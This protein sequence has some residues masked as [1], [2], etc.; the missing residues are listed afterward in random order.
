MIINSCCDTY[1]WSLTVNAIKNRLE[2]RVGKTRL[3][4]RSLIVKVPGAQ[5]LRTEVESVAE[6]LVDAGEG[7]GAGHEDLRF[8]SAISSCLRL[9][10]AG[11]IQRWMDIRSVN[12]RTL[13]NAVEHARGCVATK[14]GFVDIVVGG[15][16]RP[17][18]VLIFQDLP[19]FVVALMLKMLQ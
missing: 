19:A 6:G 10:R 1:I 15:Q 18:A 9:L 16:R 8:R 2:S 12:S 17:K 5:T 7:V 3:L 13:S 4:P 14:I 11:E